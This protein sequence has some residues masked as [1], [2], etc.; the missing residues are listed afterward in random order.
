MYLA[1]I[2]WLKQGRG[3]TL[4]KKQMGE[5]LDLRKFQKSLDISSKIH[6]FYWF[7]NRKK[8]HFICRE[9]DK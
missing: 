4:F 2:D 1:S 6:I 5:L 9:T 7:T 8:E 3:E